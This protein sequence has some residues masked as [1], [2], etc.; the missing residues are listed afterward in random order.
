MGLILRKT[1]HVINAQD[2]NAYYV[3]LQKTS[4]V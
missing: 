2:C 3:I 4:L 1:P